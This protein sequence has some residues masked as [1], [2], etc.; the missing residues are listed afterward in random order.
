MAYILA[1]HI[2][3]A[4]LACIPVFSPDIPVIFWPAHIA[5]LE[6][7]IDPV[8]SV[9][10]E[11][12]P[13]EPGIMEKPPRKIHE[14]L[15]P[16][17]NLF[18]SL[19]QGVSALLACLAAYVMCIQMDFP[20]ENTRTIVFSTLMFANLSLILVNQSWEQTV[21]AT[22]ILKN[23]ALLAIAGVT[24]M[25]FLLMLYV[26]F[27]QSIFHFTTLRWDDLLISAAC[28]ISCLTWFEIGKLFRTGR[29]PARK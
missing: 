12:Q 15:F 5:F 24:A 4:G 10:F 26:P 9:A 22:P 27:F 14:R 25:V 21:F 19:A 6:L 18:T 3:I 17:K 23:R 13:A 16:R 2:P 11:G 29:Q 7:I 20:V 28:G 8:F 1:I